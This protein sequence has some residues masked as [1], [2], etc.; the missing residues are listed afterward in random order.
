MQY[1]HT[2]VLYIRTLFIA[3]LFDD[4]HPG[5]LPRGDAAFE[6]VHLGITC[7]LDLARR[8]LRLLAVLADEQHRGALV[9]GDLRNFRAELARGD[10]ARRRQMAGGEFG[11]GAQVDHHRVARLMSCVASAADRPPRRDAARATRAGRRKPA[12]S[13]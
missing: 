8:L 4:R 2:C 3:T 7:R 11:R 13:R 12:G 6:H 1:G 5:L 10:L 9:L